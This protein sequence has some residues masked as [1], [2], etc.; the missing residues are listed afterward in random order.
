MDNLL[1]LQF[2]LLWIN[3]WTSRVLP[4][5]PSGQRWCTQH[6]S[7]QQTVLGPDVCS[8]FPSPE[9]KSPLSFSVHN[10]HNCRNT[11]RYS[12]GFL[13]NLSEVTLFNVDRRWKGNHVAALGFIGRE[14]SHFYF[15][16]KED[17]SRKTECIIRI[18][19]I[20]RVLR[21]QCHV[22]VFIYYTQTFELSGRLVMVTLSGSRT[23]MALGAVSFKYSLT[24]AS[25]SCG[26]VVVWETVTPTWHED[27]TN[28][29][30]TA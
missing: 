14:I 17:N 16:L 2:K 24:H 3:F 23:A 9:K 8:P 5:W 18:Y 22:C 4:W 20:W 30:I 19:R 28:D 11:F 12:Y 21:Q 25:R 7:G 27:A 10:P 15:W 13:S 1:Y 6:A 29:H 26:S